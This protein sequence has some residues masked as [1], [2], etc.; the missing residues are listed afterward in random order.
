MPS[1]TFADH[2][3]TFKFSTTNGLTITPK[4]GD[5]TTELSLEDLIC[6]VPSYD[7]NSYTLCYLAR[8]ASNN[9][10]ILMTAAISNP[11][12]PLLD[13]FLIS[14]LPEHLTNPPTVLVSSASGSNGA[15]SYYDNFIS[16]LLFALYDT[17]D[18][19]PPS[20]IH[21]TSATTISDTV[22][23]LSQKSEQQTILLLA[24]DTA[25]TEAINA[26][27]DHITLA[28]FPLGTG[29][30]LST[31][32]HSSKG[33][34][35]ISPLKALLHGAAKPLPTFSVQFSAG[36]KCSNGTAVEPTTGAIVVSWGVHAAVVADAEELRATVKGRERFGVAFQEI[37]KEMHRFLGKVSVRVD[38]EWKQVGDEDHFYVLATMCAELEPGF[39]IS[40]DSTP[41]EKRM[42]LVWF[43]V[44][45]PEEVGEMMAKAFDGGKHTDDERV[46]YEAV[47]GI[48]I[49]VQEKEERYRRVCIDG[50]IVTLPENGWVEAVVNDKDEGVKLVWCE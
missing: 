9:P 44:E 23:S 16:P 11:P 29:N 22:R 41:G 46:R 3:A 20:P 50:G 39:R 8:D 5:E 40:P 42:R 18:L 38:G 6:I 43:S 7:Q 17:H 32:Y 15:A 19:G 30:A 49:E 36:A 1:S 24:G 37:A 26:A 13:Q 28:I 35:L 10:E 47:E 34:P 27:K 4:G 2:P 31:S 21:T 33:H 14:K 45:K 48:R 12:K 25:I